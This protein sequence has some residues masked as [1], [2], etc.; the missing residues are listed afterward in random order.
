MMFDYEDMSIFAIQ[1][2]QQINKPE[3]LKFEYFE[4]MYLLQPKYRMSK[5]ILMID[6]QSD[7][8]KETIA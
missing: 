7:K 5:L 1:D 6:V 3:M 8:K 4:D 2:I